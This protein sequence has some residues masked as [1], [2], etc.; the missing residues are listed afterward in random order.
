MS[1]ELRCN[2]KLHG[3]L[4]DKILQIK[5]SSKWCG[6]RPGV[7]VLHHFDAESGALLETFY[8]KDPGR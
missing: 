4:D 7:V 5:C 6:A 2:G 1:F 3:V 8:F